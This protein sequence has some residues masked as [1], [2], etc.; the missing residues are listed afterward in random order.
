MH[1][2][3]CPECG[4]C[5]QY[6]GFYKNR[7]RG[8]QWT[9]YACRT[10]GCSRF[11]HGVSV[12]SRTVERKPFEIVGCIT[13]SGEDNVP[14]TDKIVSS[15]RAAPHGPSCS[16][17]MNLTVFNRGANAGTLTV[18][19]EDAAEITRRLLEG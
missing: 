12:N 13:I 17:H 8:E 4:E 9:H 6:V 2:Y 3:I 18:D 15:V 5:L 10:K 11:G 19:K 1:F 14:K 16:R 7:S